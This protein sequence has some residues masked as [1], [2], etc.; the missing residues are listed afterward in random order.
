MPSR[1]RRVATEIGRFAVV[2][3]LATLV[4]VLIFNALV[5]GYWFSAPLGDHVIWAYIIANTVGMAI[6][7][8]GSRSWAF[9]HRPPRFA[10]GGRTAYVLINIATMIL[11][12]ACL[13]FSRDVLGRTDPLSDN[14]AANVVG[15][16]LGMVAR[17]Y[18]FRTLVFLKPAGGYPGEARQEP[19]ELSQRST[20]E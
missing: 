5:H 7:Y 9:A 15:L 3:G 17:Y 1:W 10:D 14:I 13:K 19:S 2:G 18:L 12:I 4:A 20:H 8:R 16:G 6:S 11:P